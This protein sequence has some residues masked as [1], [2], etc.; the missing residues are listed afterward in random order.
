M[1][2]YPNLSALGIQQPEEIEKFFVNSVSRN[3]ILR[4]VYARDKG[5]LFRE[6]RS[7]KFPRIQTSDN[8]GSGLK[9]TGITLETDPKL[10]RVLDE[11][12]DLLGEKGRSEAATETI[13]EELESLQEEIAV[14]L[15]RMKQL[16]R[17]K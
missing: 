3:D 1:K 17:E 7:Y 8:S 13:L 15:Q 16:V 14:R 9:Q 11:L 6:S 12:R 5:S 4:I 10:R 2:E